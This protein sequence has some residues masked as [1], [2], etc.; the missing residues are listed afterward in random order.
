VPIV[1]DHVTPNPPLATVPGADQRTVSAKVSTVY[2][3]PI[4]QRQQAVVTRDGQKVMVV[5]TMRDRDGR[6][7]ELASLMQTTVPAGTDPVTWLV[8]NANVTLGIREIVSMTAGMLA[9]F[10]GSV[11]DAGSGI[12]SAAI[13]P[14]Q[15]AGPGIFTSEFILRDTAGNILF[16]NQFMLYVE[17]S[18]FGSI[19][20]NG[21]P[22]IGEIRLQL[23]DSSPDEN[24]LL[25]NVTFD[26][27]E[28]AL[29]LTRTVQYYNEVPP[30]LTTPYTTQ[31]F[32]SRW[33]WIEGAI[34]VLFRIV[35][36]YYR[37][38]HLAYQA[39]GI[40]VDDM[41]KAAEYD[42][43]ADRRWDGFTKWTTSNKMSKNVEEGW[44]EIDSQYAISQHGWWWY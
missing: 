31:N 23:R 2:D 41:N 29:A 37:K 25:D 9:P 20:Y 24:R 11:V 42:Q 43:A 7:V 26:D 36:E 1:A 10:P 12:V 4:P 35:A 18:L 33:F 34:S 40:A 3:V 6:P 28:I 19:T 21:P 22:T 44:G 39:G 17:P 27:A 16:G 8:A 13:D 5:W 38:N 30:P 14:T 32:P 15:F